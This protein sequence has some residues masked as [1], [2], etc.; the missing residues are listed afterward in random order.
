VRTLA[1]Y[2][3]LVKFR[4]K[5]KLKIKN[6]KLTCDFGAFQLSKV[7]EKKSKNHKIFYIW[8]SLCSQKH[9]RA[10]KEFYFIL[11]M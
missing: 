10:I 1:S 2:A 5:V 7:R 9:R 6:L 8:F 11:C 3:L 4:P